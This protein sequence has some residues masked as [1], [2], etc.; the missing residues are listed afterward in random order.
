MLT[1]TEVRLRRGPQVLI[2]GAT[3]SIFRGEKAGI[4]VCRPKPATAEE[5]R[6]LGAR[7]G[8]LLR[9]IDALEER[10]LEVAAALEAAG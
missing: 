6:R 4:A 8:E 7:H 10:W 2:D 5:Q 3:C 9:E 1:L